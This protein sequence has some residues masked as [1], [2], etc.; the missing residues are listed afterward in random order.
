M[1]EMLSDFEIRR[2]A[3]QAKLEMLLGSKYVYFNVPAHMNHPCIKYKLASVSP[4]FA[5]NLQYKHRY[6]WDLTLIEHDKTSDLFKRIMEYFKTCSFG[7]DYD[8]DNLHH[9]VLRLE[10]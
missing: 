6:S 4:L 2:R 1:D 10:F 7:T 8:V 3:L 5:D 9:T